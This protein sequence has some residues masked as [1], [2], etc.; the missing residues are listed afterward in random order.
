MAERDNN[1]A[2]SGSHTTQALADTPRWQ[3]PHTWP[4]LVGLLLIAGI[5]MFVILSIQSI[6]S[7]LDSFDRTAS[8]QNRSL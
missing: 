8:A 2:E 3:K 1:P 6:A 7:D 4:E 5:A